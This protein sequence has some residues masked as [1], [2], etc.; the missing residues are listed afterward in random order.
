[1]TDRNALIEGTIKVFSEKGIKF[2]MDDVAACMG[3]SK[4]TIYKIFPNKKALMMAAIDYGF[5]AIK[6]EER[7]IYDNPDL[8]TSEKIRKI[9]GAMPESYR[10]LDFRE[11]VA[12]RAKFPD[13]YARIE[14]RL[15]TG[16]ELTISLLEQGMREGSIRKI[17][18]PVFKTIFEA[19]LEHFLTRDVLGLNNITYDAALSELCDVLMQGIEVRD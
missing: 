7:A 12:A 9:L 5:D 4:K 3:M 10:N 6:A 11:I 8:T 19:A 2:T 18:I 1:M 15:E 17:D 16:W 13:M 14:E